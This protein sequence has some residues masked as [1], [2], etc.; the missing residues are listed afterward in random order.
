MKPGQFGGLKCIFNVNLAVNNN[1][2]DQTAQM[3]SLVSIITVCIQQ[4]QTFSRCGWNCLINVQQTV[5]IDSLQWNITEKICT[6]FVR[7]S[8][9][10]GE[11]DVWGFQVS[12]QV[13][14]KSG[15]VKLD[16]P[17][18]TV[19]F[20]LFLGLE[21]CQTWCLWIISHWDKMWI[22]TNVAMNHIES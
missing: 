18:L 4:K 22:I 8:C 7:Y 17:I 3:R 10:N 6:C 21:I 15:V 5:L 9:I 12:Y 13:G 11:C 19:E 16:E 14:E 2:A 20:R 1:D